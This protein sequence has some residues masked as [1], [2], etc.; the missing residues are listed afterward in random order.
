MNLT[1]NN[2]NQAT[3]RSHLFLNFVFNRLS[4]VTFAEKKNGVNTITNEKVA[5][6]N[7]KDNESVRSPPSVPPKQPAV[8]ENNTDDNNTPSWRR[9]NGR[10]KN[11]NN[12]TTPIVKSTVSFSE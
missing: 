9:P 6:I 11:D 2:N 1:V 3:N 4:C 8:V 7:E 12:K 10:Q 5:D